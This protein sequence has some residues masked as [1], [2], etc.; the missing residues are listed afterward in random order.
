MLAEDGVIHKAGIHPSSSQSK[1]APLLGHQAQ[2]RP[3]LGQMKR[4]EPQEAAVLALSVNAK[5]L[6]RTA[7][8]FCCGPWF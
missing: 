8:D 3:Q 5:G 2:P 4:K 6:L 7:A 1:I